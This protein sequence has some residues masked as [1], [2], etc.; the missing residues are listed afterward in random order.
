MMLDEICDS[1]NLSSMRLPIVR[2][3]KIRFKLPI[4]EFLSFQIRD[5]HLTKAATL[6][7]CYAA[8][9]SHL[10][11]ARVAARFLAVTRTGTGIQFCS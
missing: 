1:P 4:K 9:P 8:I 7:R 3:F 5:D 6:L 2:I 10:R 11:S